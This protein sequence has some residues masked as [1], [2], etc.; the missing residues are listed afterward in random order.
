M[1][2]DIRNLHGA[3]SWG[4]LMTPDPSA[5]VKFYEKVLGWR[6]EE[7]EMPDGMGKYTVFATASGKQVAGAMLP[8]PNVPAG[9]PPHWAIYVTVDDVDAAA[10]AATEG[11]G[12]I[13]LPPTDVPG[14]GRM[15]HILDPQN[16]MIALITY[17]KPFE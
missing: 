7:M 9:T 11:G 5:A 16:A 1:S 4:E 13:L 10:E 6:A 14:V 17:E 2:S 8:P 3:L 15:C 12:T